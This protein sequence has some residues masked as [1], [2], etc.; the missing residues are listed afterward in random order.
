MIKYIYRI[1]GIILFVFCL[2]SIFTPKEIHTVD[3][4]IYYDNVRYTDNVTFYGVDGLNLQYSG[5]L[6]SPG[7][8]YELTFDVVNSSNT[9]VEIVACDYHKE[10]A[11]VD[12]ELFYEDGTKVLVGD[13][14]KKGE[15]KSLTYRV[16][17]KNVILLDSYQFDASFHIGYEQIL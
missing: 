4:K 3:S 17:Y 16:L 7:E 1:I 5:N 6:T 11:Y 10:D 12:Y 13:V 8:F 9:D 15:I 14:L 2:G